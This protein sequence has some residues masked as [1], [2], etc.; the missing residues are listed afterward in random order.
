MIKKNPELPI[1]FDLDE[2]VEMLGLRTEEKTAAAQQRLKNTYETLC[3]ECTENKK[4]SANQPTESSFVKFYKINLLDKNSKQIEANN[5]YNNNINLDSIKS[6]NDAI[7]NQN[8]HL[9]CVICIE[10]HKSELEAKK[11]K[12]NYS[13]NNANSNKN[14]NNKAFNDL[15]EFEFLCGIC[16]KK[17]F[18]NVKV[19]EN[20]RNKKACCAGCS[21]F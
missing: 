8:M 21:I 1:V 9:L 15:I 14:L 20:G 18:T 3:C 4:T 11:A 10:K 13:I 6:K 17:H 12:E 16:N 2:S 5:N 7:N 19:D